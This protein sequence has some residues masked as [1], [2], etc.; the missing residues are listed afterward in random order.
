[1]RTIEA[2]VH[3]TK[4]RE[5]ENNAKALLGGACVMGGLLEIEEE[6]GGGTILSCLHS[7]EIS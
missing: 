7:H 3:A 1:M 6:G 4:R 2:Q 5:G